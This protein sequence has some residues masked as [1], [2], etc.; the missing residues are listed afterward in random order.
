MGIVKNINATSFPE[1]YIADKNVLV[2]IGRKVNV[3]FR[4]NTDIMI[5]GVVIRDDKGSPF[6]TIIRLSDGRVVLA[7]ECQF[8]ASGETDKSVIEQFTFKNNGEV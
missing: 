5:D 7:E 1:Q 3:C 4:F 2:G 6:Q 8:H